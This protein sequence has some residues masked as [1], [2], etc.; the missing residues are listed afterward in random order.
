MVWIF[1]HLSPQKAL[2]TKLPFTKELIN[3]WEW[4][5]RTKLGLGSNLGPLFYYIK[6]FSSVKIGSFLISPY[7]GSFSHSFHGN[8]EYASPSPPSPTLHHSQGASSSSFPQALLIHVFHPHLLSSFIVCQKILFLSPKKCAFFSLSSLQL[9][10]GSLLLGV[11]PTHGS[12]TFLLPMGYPMLS[13]SPFGYRLKLAQD[14]MES[15]KRVLYLHV[16]LPISHIV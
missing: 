6:R 11:H 2:K 13:L 16:F 15:L 12:L 14:L 7:T 9:D 10:L 8:L 1:F 4:G 3:Q 5:L